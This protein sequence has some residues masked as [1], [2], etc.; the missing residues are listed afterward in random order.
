MITLMAHSYGKLVLDAGRGTWFFL[1]C[2]YLQ[3]SFSIFIIWQLVCLKKIILVG[4]E[5]AAMSFVN[6][7]HFY[8]ILLVMQAG[9][10]DCIS[11][12]KELLEV[13]CFWGLCWKQITTRTPVQSKK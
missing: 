4:K 11:T 1:M 3:N 6:C 9:V 10:E 7:P 13:G 12:W 8:N 2:L 5:E